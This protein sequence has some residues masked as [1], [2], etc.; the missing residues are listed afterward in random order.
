MLAHFHRLERRFRLD[1]LMAVAFGASAV[2]WLAIAA[3]DAPAL[4]IGLQLL[5]GL[6]FGMFWST[7][8]ASIAATVPAR[9]APP[10]RRCW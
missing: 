6:T 1:I 7:A 9:C 10:D 8:I 3:I 4:L 2:R 5:H